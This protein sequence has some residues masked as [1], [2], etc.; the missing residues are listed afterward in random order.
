MY[1]KAEGWYT[2][3]FLSMDTNADDTTVTVGSR[4]KI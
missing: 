1:P 2:N 3:G 4:L